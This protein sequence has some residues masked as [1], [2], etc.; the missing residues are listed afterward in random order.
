MIPKT[1][2]MGN[3]KYFAMQATATKAFYFYHGTMISI[4]DRI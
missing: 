3:Y 2:V 4:S 1:F